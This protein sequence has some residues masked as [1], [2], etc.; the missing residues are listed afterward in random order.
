MGQIITADVIDG[1][2]QIKDRTCDTCITS[3][4]YYGLRDYGTGIWEGGD[5]SCNHI[6]AEIRTGISLADAPASI[7]GGAKKLQEI[8][9]LQARTVC[10]KCGAF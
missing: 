5:T 1:L 6:V 2:R 9:K 4:P 3:P 7:R 8:P 10:P